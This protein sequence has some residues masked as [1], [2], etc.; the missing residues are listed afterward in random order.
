MA[1]L[2]RAGGRDV[3]A[4]KLLLLVACNYCCNHSYLQCNNYVAATTTF[5]LDV[6]SNVRCFNDADGV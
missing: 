3:V 5:I 1:V 2:S 4:V 6:R